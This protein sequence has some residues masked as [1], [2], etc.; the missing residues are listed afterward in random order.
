MNLDRVS[1]RLKLER[2]REPYWQRISTGQALGYRPSA[3]G[4]GGHWLAKSNDAGTRR[5][6]YQVLGEFS[7]LPAHEQHRAALKAAREWFDHIDG[8]GAK[9][10]P[11]TVRQVCERYAQNRLDAQ[12]RFARYVYNDP[13][14]SI[15][16]QKLTERHVK[17]WRNRL[18][19]KPALVTR[20]PA[21]PSVT[22]D[23]EPAT[24][25]RDMVAF[26]AALNQALAEG[27]ILSNRAWRTALRPNKTL[28]ARRNVY[29]DKEQRRA[30]VE[31]LPHDVSEFAKGLALLP[32]RP[33]AVAALQVADF[34]PR[35]RELIVARDKSDQG[36]RIFL[37]QETVDFL[38]SLAKKRG[39]GERL[40]TR[41]NGSSWNK[42][43]WKWP[44][45]AVVNK[46]QLPEKTTAYTFR[47]STITD[48]VAQGLDLLTV[49]RV[50][51]T[52]VLMIERH[53]GHLKNEVAAKALAALSL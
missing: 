23:R 44:I 51:G 8:G 28:G 47:H 46:L 3:K 32:L 49:A 26:R 11:S 19:A 53:Y 7:Q 42:D 18:E 39:A 33:G 50:S 29:L 20:S 35:R 40:F 15:S 1:L 41:A 37:P 6:S 34:D 31:A 24:T 14:A 30:L 25:N 10:R 16:L 21:K 27:E 45:K 12:K 22:K 36:R 48:L 43:A 4:G 13:I 9:G 38:Q 2:R 5:R 52:S 17:D